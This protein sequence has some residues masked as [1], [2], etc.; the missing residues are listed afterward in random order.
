M[1]QNPV[2]RQRT[3]Q[4]LQVALGT[5]APCSLG[6]IPIT[7]LQGRHRGRNQCLLSPRQDGVL[8]SSEVHRPF[9]SA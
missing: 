1:T 3:E 4:R 8:V 6:V 7:L 9:P 2:L 5:S